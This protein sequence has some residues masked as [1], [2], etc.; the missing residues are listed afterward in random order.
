MD[1]KFH[2]KKQSELLAD[3]FLNRCSPILVLMLREGSIPIKCSKNTALDSRTDFHKNHITRISQM[4]QTSVSH[5]DKAGTIVTNNKVLVGKCLSIDTPTSGAVMSGNVTTCF[6]TQHNKTK[7]TISVC[8]T[9]HCSKW[10]Q[11]CSER[12]ITG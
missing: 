2:L 11:K 4:I 12:M 8:R 7:C 1:L 10:M 5:V 6:Q 9:H 3:T